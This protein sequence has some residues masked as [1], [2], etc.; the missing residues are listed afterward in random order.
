[1]KVAFGYANYILL[2]QI[3]SHLYGGPMPGRNNT[4]S[5]IEKGKKT[6]TRTYTHTYIYRYIYI[7]REE[8]YRVNV[9]ITI[10]AHGV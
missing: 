6:Q 8:P 3:K 5:P 9:R 4:S 1:M 10:I 7:S 2:V